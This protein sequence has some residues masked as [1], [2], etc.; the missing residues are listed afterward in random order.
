MAAVYSCGDVSVLPPQCS[1]WMNQVNFLPHSVWH[2]DLSHRLLGH[3]GVA[4]CGQGQPSNSVSDIFVGRVCEIC[5]I[6]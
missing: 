5:I 4:F 1:T 3:C 6:E 2:I